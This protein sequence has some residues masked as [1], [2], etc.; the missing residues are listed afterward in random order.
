MTVQQKLEK[1]LIDN[2]MF[3][4]QAKEV[5]KLAIP[6]LNALVDDYQISFNSDAS[7]YPNVIYNVLFKAIKPIALK[8]IED[9]IPLAWYK[10]MFEN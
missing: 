8:W 6:D 7:S 5:M 2:G 10:P 4:T 9:N 3:D 1:M